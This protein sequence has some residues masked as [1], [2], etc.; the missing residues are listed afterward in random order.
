MRIAK[1]LLL[2]ITVGLLAS[3]VSPYEPPQENPEYLEIQFQ[4]G[5]NG[6]TK[7]FTLSK[8]HNELLDGQKFN[9]KTAAINYMSQNGWVVDQIY[10]PNDAKGRMMDGP[11]W[12]FRKD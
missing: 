9:S 5:L 1:I 3:A 7:F 10:M 4:I 12:L 8:D 2:V 11:A 6:G